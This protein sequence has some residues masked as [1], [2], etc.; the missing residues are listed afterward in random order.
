[1]NRI[2]TAIANFLIKVSVLLLYT[3]AFL[4]A[5]EYTINQVQ[6]AKQQVQ[7]AKYDLKTMAAKMRIFL[8]QEVG[9]IDVSI[10]PSPEI[11]AYAQYDGQNYVV[12]FFKGIIDLAENADQ[13]ALVLGHEISHHMLG[14]TGGTKINNE[15]TLADNW[16]SS[17]GHELMADTLG[18]LLAK[19]A[20][21][22]PCEG[23]RFWA[24]MAEGAVI[25][26]SAGASH[27][28][29]F[30]RATNI[31]KVFDCKAN[32]ADEFARVRTEIE[33]KNAQQPQLMR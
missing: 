6:K 20:G 21:Y 3:L 2:L 27:P 8:P 17:Q 23:I 12:V 18:G 19:R 28:A 22:N 25:P 29:P 24:L 9:K 30:E 14:H 7:A 13:V 31:N 10:N 4:G 26:T 16:S 33:V 1:M 32:V 11:N 15:Y 5:T